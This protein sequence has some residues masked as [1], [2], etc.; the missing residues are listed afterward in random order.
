MKRKILIISLLL[1][2]TFTSVQTF[3]KNDKKAIE[4]KVAAMTKEQKDTRIAEIK[5]RVE[6]IKNMD[7]SKLTSADK[8][9]LRHELRDMN[10]ESKAMGTGGVYISLGALIVIILLLILIL[11]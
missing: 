7:K 1:L 4:E 6:E 11:K 3:A 9:A 10:T 5:A 8:K 2:S